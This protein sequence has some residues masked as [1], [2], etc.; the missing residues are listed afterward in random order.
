MAELPTLYVLYGSATG[1]AEHIAKDLAAEAEKQLKEEESADNSNVKPWFSKVYVGE[2]DTFKKK[3]SPA[4]EKPIDG[5]GVESKHPVIVVCSTTG[6]G[7]STENSNRYVRYLKRKPTVQAKPLVNVIYATLGLG[8]T[9]YEKFCNAARIIDKQM[10]ECGATKLQ[11]IKCADEATGL[12]DVVEPFKDSILEL[13]GKAMRSLLYPEECGGDKVADAPAKENSN[14]SDTEAEEK[15]E[16]PVAEQKAAVPTA[17]AAPATKETE[18]APVSVALPVE[19]APV[20]EEVLTTGVAAMELSPDGNTINTTN[21]NGVELVLSLA[22]ELNLA[23][24]INSSHDSTPPIDVCF[25]PSIGPSRSS[26]QLLSGKD[27]VDVQALKSSSA[28][29]QD[30]DID[31]DD[32][33][34]YFTSSRPYESTLL[35]ARYLSNT[36][37]STSTTGAAQKDTAA[38][39]TTTATTTALNELEALGQAYDA[40]SAGF[41]L[42]QP[43]NDK[44]V[45]ELTLSLPN[46]E[47]H[48]VMKYQP[49]DAVGMVIP[50][51]PHDIL[52]V[53]NMLKLDPFALVKIGNDLQC[54]DECTHMTVLEAITWEMD[55]HAPL[56]PR[57]LC[58]L[59]QYC[60]DAEDGSS[61]NATTAQMEAHVLQLLSCS[62]P[63]GQQLFNSLI[64]NNQMGCADVLRLFQTCHPPLEALLGLL[65][66]LA[67]RY[68]SV[69]SSPLTSVASGG[70]ASGSY[71]TQLKVALAAVDY[72]TPQLG[73]KHG[74]A[75]R[76][77][78]ALASPNLTKDEAS[79]YSNISNHKIKLFPKPSSDMGE[80]FHLPTNTATPLVLIG[81][82]T[83]VAPFMGFLEHRR[84]QQQQ[85]NEDTASNVKFGSIDLFFGC[86]SVK[87]DF[88]YKEELHALKEEGVLTNLH[89]AFSRDDPDKKT[90]V[91]DVMRDPLVAERLRTLIVD[92]E[93]SKACVYIC[94][95]GNAMAKDV[96]QALKEILSVS[97]AV[98]VD[99]AD[100]YLQRLKDERRLLLDIWM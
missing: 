87:Q 48:A 71:P 70:D 9:N 77:L 65:S 83:G 53:V 59:A 63:Q 86:R 25:L 34:H 79:S 10:E 33:A 20:K 23:V 80:E 36:S 35:G 55:L 96:Q 3:C 1:N 75:T 44:R 93:N 66:G 12:E 58:G 94:G 81:P 60:V 57:M 5:F 40:I 45:M 47:Q 78:E 21:S 15:K 100:A 51:A 11:P 31:H 91:Q 30:N 46:H 41:D 92:N 24:N 84:N 89:T 74:L 56:K 61:T 19:V 88:I 64:T 69:C 52:T 8:D 68:Y 32:E 6:N 98:G 49:G 67:P 42:T 50:N 43:F 7:E 22:K 62:T 82:G 38:D 72:N 73:R 54:D 29:A 37:M 27:H 99:N 4:W 90:Y 17:A 13:M 97:P 39:T 95:D 18:S 16:E 28:P 14:N 2:C 26:A 85:Q 76:Y